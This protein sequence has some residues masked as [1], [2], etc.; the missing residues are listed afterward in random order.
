MIKIND[1]DLKLIIESIINEVFSGNKVIAY[2]GTPHGE[3]D[4][5]SLEHRGS[6]ADVA[7]FGDFGNGFYFSPDRE[8]AISY[9][10]NVGKKID[11]DDNRPTLYTVELT[12]NKPFNLREFSR[13]QDD[14]FALVKKYGGVFNLPNGTFLNVLEKHGLTEEEYE[15]FKEIEDE[16]GDNW[17][18][19]DIFKKLSEFGFDSIIS[20]D[21][22]E[23]VVPSEKQIKIIKVE[24]L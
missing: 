11:L 20:Y 16:I 18:D 19:F 22:T 13:I 9:A 5:F 4:N 2:H 15:F 3:F 12:M 1:K 17:A 10:E 6:G 23:Y 24:K 8:L 14:F 7:G 21:G